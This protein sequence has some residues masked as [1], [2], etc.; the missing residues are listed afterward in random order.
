M[1]HASKEITVI[2]L[3]SMDDR[4]AWDVLASA[5]FDYP[6]MTYLQPDPLKRKKFLSWYLGFTIRIGR[7]YG[8]ILST[9]ELKGVAVWLPPKACWVSDKQFIN[10]GMLE[11]PFRMGLKAFKRILVNDNYLEEIRRKNAP[12]DHWYLWAVGVDPAHK[13]Q[14]IGSALLKPVLIE[15]DNT[16]IDCYLET[17]LKSNLSWYEKLGFKVIVEGEI[18][19]YS[20]PVWAMIRHPKTV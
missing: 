3:N 10:A 2:D 4:K 19:G 9:P 6:L 5:F 18:P 8:K 7:K 14:G 11:T 13:Y 16:G 12:E 20:I 15:A 1:G 17:H